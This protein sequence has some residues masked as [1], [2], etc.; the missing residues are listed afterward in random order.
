MGM[1]KTWEWEKL[2]DQ[3]VQELRQRYLRERVQVSRKTVWREVPHLIQVSRRSA[4][5]RQWFRELGLKRQFVVRGVA[6]SR[7]S[8]KAVLLGEFAAAQWGMWFATPKDHDVQFALPSGHLPPKSSL[9]VSTKFKAFQTPPADTA[10]L[11]GV[12]VTH[13]LRTYVDY[14]R[15]QKVVNARLAI[16]WLLRHGFTADEI[17]DYADNFEGSMHPR[18]RRLAA[19][20][21]YQ[22]P[23]L[24]TYPYMLAH[25]LLDDS[26]VKLRTHCELDRLGFATL[27]AG[28]D[29]VILIDEDPYWRALESEPDGLMLAHNRRKRER[30]ESAR[31]F[32]KMYFTTAEIERAPK[33]FV[34]EVLG[35]MYLRDRGLVY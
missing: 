2:I 30:W 1:G 3:D 22:V 32:R 9:P 35:A 23:Q 17:S 33:S 29:L 27:L 16:G 14:C 19:V 13:P 28:N 24:E 8:R 26:R 5:D 34:N 4:V 11:D 21:P 25:S 18:R 20:L 31:G 15:M 12:R 7:D 6:A 10:E